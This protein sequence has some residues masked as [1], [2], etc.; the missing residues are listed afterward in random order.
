[1]WIKDLKNYIV[2]TMGFVKYHRHYVC[3]V[4]SYSSGKADVIPEDDEI[5]GLAGLSKVPVYMGIP[6]VEVTVLP[7][8]KV[9]LFF[10]DGDPEKPR[11]MGWQSGALTITLAD[12]VLGVA[13]I[14]DT[15]TGTIQGLDSSSLPV[16]GTFNGIIVGGSAKVKAG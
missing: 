6:G 9:T 13:R 12:G 10:E 5:K 11:I 7:G 15:V 2:S 1:M 8:A 4:Q 3:T 14:G 16:T